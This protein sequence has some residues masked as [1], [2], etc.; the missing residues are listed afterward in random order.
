MKGFLAALQFLTIL[1]IQLKSVTEKEL[2]WSMTYFPVVGFCV[3]LMLVAVSWLLTSVGIQSYLLCLFLV[4]FLVVITGGLHLDGL[5]DTADGF[6]SGTSSRDML[7]IMRDSRIGTMG[8]LSLVCVILAEIFLLKEVPRV[9]LPAA[10]LL[11][12]LVSRWA[13][14]LLMFLF[15]YARKE[16]KA[17]AYMAGR[18]NYIGILSS[19]LALLL[20]YLTWGFWGI[21]LMAVVAIAVVI[22]GAYCSKKIGGIT[23]DTLGAANEIIQVVTL[24][25]I[26]IMGRMNPCLV[27]R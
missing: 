11:M 26:F 5:A 4:I 13:M 16:G 12:C 25:V 22:F 7:V 17:M 1:P 6:L 3:G 18:K 20:A 14:V 27:L 21:C 2:A 19:T 24:L 8:V 9:F 23:G 10:V 15:P